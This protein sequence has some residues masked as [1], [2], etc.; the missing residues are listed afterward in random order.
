MVPSPSRILE[1]Y[2]QFCVALFFV[3]IGVTLIQILTRYVTV[4]SQLLQ[5]LSI[6]SS[7]I[8]SLLLVFLM[9]LG[10]VVAQLREDH[11]RI[12]ILERYLVDQDRYP[13]LTG[14]YHYSIYILTAIMVAALTYA[15]WDLMVRQWNTFTRIQ[16]LQLKNGQIYAVFFLSLGAILCHIFYKIWTGQAPNS[17][18]RTA[19]D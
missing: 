9:M 6:W 8:A 16:G 14:G 4:E 19:D 17:A 12:T 7:E 13:R 18:T 11:I 5:S 2:E 10:A 15:S 3:M 1:R